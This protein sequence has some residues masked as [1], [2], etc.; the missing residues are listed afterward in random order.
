MASVVIHRYVKVGGD[1]VGKAK[2]HI[3]YIQHRRGED[4]ERSVDDPTGPKRR[5]LFDGERDSLDRRE[6]NSLIDR[7]R[8]GGVAIHKLTL[9]PGVQGVDLKEYTREVMDE[10][11]KEKGLNLQYAAAAHR[12][13]DHDHV[14]VVILGTDANGQRVRIDR[15]DHDLLRYKSDQYLEREHAYDRELEREVKEVERL[16]REK[17]WERDED[18]LGSILGKGQVFGRDFDERKRDDDRPINLMLGTDAG[19]AQ[20]D[21]YYKTDDLEK[22]KELEKD[23][24]EG[25][26][27]VR[28]MG[29]ENYERLKGWIEERNR[30]DAPQPEREPWSKEQAIEAMSERDKL[31]IQEKTYTKYDTAEDL[32]GLNQHLSTHYED[33]IDKQQYAMLQRW[34]ETKERNGDDCHEKWD[35]ERYD[36]KEKDREEGREASQSTREWHEFDKNAK[37]VFEDRSG[38]I[39]RHMPRQQRIF[40]ARGRNLEYHTTYMNSMAKQRLQEARERSNDPEVLKYIDKELEMLKEYSAELAR[41]MPT[42]DLDKLYGRDAEKS[43]E[44]EPDRPLNLDDIKFPDALDDSKGADEKADKERE[45]EKEQDKGGEKDKNREQDEP[46]KEPDE[47]EK[48]LEPETGEKEPEKPERTNEQSQQ[49]EAQRQAREAQEQA[50]QLGERQGQDIHEKIIFKSKIDDREDDER[51]HDDRER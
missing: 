29:E 15:S 41:D 27:H 1:G 45:P 9:S 39:H 24:Q 43:R 20:I 14:H 19:D 44:R 38:V 37:K 16:A 51:E 30:E 8:Q 23:Y 48:A 22:L 4:K 33:R 28:S 3:R 7:E 2:A 42:I 36:K 40:E 6:I 12:N 13:T 18:R 5:E 49:Q 35:K 21:S 26:G 10:L 34:I 46:Q 50:Q 32:K 31:T 25:D 11:G 47:H 17:G